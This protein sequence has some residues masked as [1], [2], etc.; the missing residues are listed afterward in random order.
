MVIASELPEGA[1]V[2]GVAEGRRS[3][4]AGCRL[5]NEPAGS[6]KQKNEDNRRRMKEWLI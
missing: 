6:R 5:D 3:G 4:G 2:D 1:V